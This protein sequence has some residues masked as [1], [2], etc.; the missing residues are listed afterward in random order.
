[1]CFGAMRAKLAR[2]AYD[3]WAALVR[4]VQLIA[5]NAMRY[6]RRRSR[7]HRQ[8]L[9]LLRAGKKLLAEAELEGRKAFA[10]LG[11]GPGLLCPGAV[12]LEAGE[13]S[14]RAEPRPPEPGSG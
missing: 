9:V 3:S 13:L 12:R 4:D 6:N 14:R 8:A 7:V 10:A 2:G 11:K 5:S 1:M